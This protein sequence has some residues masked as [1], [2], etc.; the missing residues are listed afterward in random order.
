MN[1]FRQFLLPFPNQHIYDLKPAI[2]KRL[3][4]TFIYARVIENIIHMLHTL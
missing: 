4:T 2:S 3:I 1:N